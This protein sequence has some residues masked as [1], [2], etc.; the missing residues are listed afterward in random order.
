MA[1]FVLTGLALFQVYSLWNLLQ[2]FELPTNFKRC[3]PSSVTYEIL[4][5]IL[6][7]DP[8]L[9]ENSWNKLLL[10]QYDKIDRDQSGAMMSILRD[11]TSLPMVI[12][13]FALYHKLNSEDLLSFSRSEL[14]EFVLGIMEQSENIRFRIVNGSLIGMFMMERRT[15]PEDWKEFREFERSVSLLSNGIGN[16]RRILAPKYFSS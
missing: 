1:Y 12:A 8:N 16:I 3:D 6:H 11:H 4:D 7:Y 5:Q 9:T 2:D 14:N 13:F 15:R 10:R